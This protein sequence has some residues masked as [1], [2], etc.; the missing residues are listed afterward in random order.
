MFQYIIINAAKMKEYLTIIYIQIVDIVF[1]TVLELFNFK[2]SENIVQ[3]AFCLILS[4]CPL[5]QCVFTKYLYYL[6]V[7]AKILKD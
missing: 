1:L 6:F 5:V 7:V 3:V 2:R 4:P